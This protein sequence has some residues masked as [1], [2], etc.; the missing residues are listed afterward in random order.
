MVIRHIIRR[1]AMASLTTMAVLL[2]LGV[3]AQTPTEEF[4]LDPFGPDT[5]RVLEQDN[6]ILSMAGGRRLLSEGQAAASQGNY[7]R[8]T[9]QFQDARQVF[10][11]LSNFYQQLSS[12]F[13]GINSRRA[14]QQRRQALETAQL[15]DQ[16][17]YE[18]A[19]AHQ[20]QGRTDLAV[21]L[22]IQI[23]R[24]QNP[25][26]TLGRQA[27][28]D[29][30]RFGFVAPSGDFAELVPEAAPVLLSLD[31]GEALM[32]EAELAVSSGNYPLAED[33]LKQS[34]Q[35]FNQL[36]NFHQQLASTFSG[37]DGAVAQDQRDKALRTAQ[38]RDRSTYQL[39]LIHR[40]QGQPELAVPLLIQIV[41]SQ[42]PTTDLGE[43]AYQQLVE[44]GFVQ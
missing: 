37:I 33:K 3:Q 2:P 27:H 40:A 8:A 11:Q 21:P 30:V 28:R 6:S 38:L 25:T 10:N 42:N 39:A 12:S 24:S 34:R 9:Q 15:R 13:A 43:R 18:L 32:G 22:L 16:A 19:M 31:G 29:L 17:T 44:L 4:E 26:T 41:R 7:D 35:V 20:S 14:E 23:I 36:S 1:F 5:Q